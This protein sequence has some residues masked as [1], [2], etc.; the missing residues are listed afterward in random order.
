V[1]RRPVLLSAAGLAGGVLA[2]PGCGGRPP[3]PPPPPTVLALRL[4]ASP[5]VNPDGAG[6]PKPLRVRVLQLAG[7]TALSQADFFALDADPGKALGPELLASEDVVLSPGQT[8]SLEREAK[9]GAR[10]VG[11]AGAYFAIDRARWRAWA[12]V[13]PNARNSY[14]A[15]CDA[16][17][18][19]LAEGGA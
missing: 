11:V 12:P 5:D 16:A 9:P 15:S 8:T 19:K 4:A 18:V 7:T 3:P 14:V 2:A 1:N 10:F 13:R 17:E 6:T